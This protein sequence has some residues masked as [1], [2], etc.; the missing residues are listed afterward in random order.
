MKSLPTKLEGVVLLEP[1]VHGDARGFMV[2]TYRR[3]TWAE[4]GVGVE[5]VQHNHSRSSRGTLRG[6]HFQTEPGQVLGTLGYTSP[7]QLR[8]EETDFASD[9]F[10]LGCVLY[11]MMTGRPAFRR[12]NSAETIAAILTEEPPALETVTGAPLELSRIVQRCME[13]RAGA[14]FQSA[15]DL[16]FALR[17]LSVSQNVQTERIVRPHRRHGVPSGGG[18]EPE[19]AGAAGGNDQERRL[20]VGSEPIEHRRVL[21][22]HPA[23]GRAEHGVERAGEGQPTRGRGRTWSAPMAVGASPL[24]S[25]HGVPSSGRSDRRGPWRRRA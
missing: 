19:G 21:A 15:S 6:L 1:T 11:E 24:S 12:G 3:D 20:A 18:F 2:E 4:L 7:E 5:F 9:L 10:S 17:H 25:S 13:K 14:R 22:R 16:A 8:G 23:Q